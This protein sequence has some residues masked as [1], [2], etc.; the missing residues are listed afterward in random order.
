MQSVKAAPSVANNACWIIGELAMKVRA[1]FSN[2][3]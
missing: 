2:T 3:S 1:A